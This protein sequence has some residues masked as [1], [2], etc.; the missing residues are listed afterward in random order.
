[1]RYG[2]LLTA[3]LGVGMGF[4]VWAET[5][6]SGPMQDGGGMMGRGMM[7]GKMYA[8]QAAGQA[9]SNFSNLCSS[10]H[11]P[12]GKGNGPAA[13]ALNPKPRDFSDCKV[14]AKDT[15]DIL[16]KAIKGG[17]QSIGRSAMMVSW[18]GALTDEQIHELVSYV[19]SFCKK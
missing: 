3:I 11:G 9:A 13:A 2:F 17:G 14:M 5:Q 18:G 10:C 7:G 16:F 15:D 19:R 6:K 12:S 4:S 1:M 8:A